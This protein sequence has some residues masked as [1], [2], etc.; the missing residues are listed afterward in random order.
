MKV[1]LNLLFSTNEQNNIQG[2]RLP[3]KKNE[4]E[5]EIIDDENVKG[6]ELR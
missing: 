2:R 3:I 5:K 6:D 1:I 4:S